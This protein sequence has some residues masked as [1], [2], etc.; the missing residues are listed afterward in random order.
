[1]YVMDRMHKMDKIMTIVDLKRRL[2]APTMTAISRLPARGWSFRGLLL[3]DLNP[4][5]L[6]I[7]QYKIHS[8]LET[9]SV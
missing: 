8:D 7:K 9:L 6:Q 2:D 4:K 3:R 5:E 1:M